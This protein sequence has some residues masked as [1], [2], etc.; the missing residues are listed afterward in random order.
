MSGVESVVIP[1]PWALVPSAI[2]SSPGILDLGATSGPHKQ[3][4]GTEI[5]GLFRYPCIYMEWY[6]HESTTGEGWSRQLASD[7]RIIDWLLRPV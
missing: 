3:K 5:L 4:S 6:G 1:G 2:G 7:S